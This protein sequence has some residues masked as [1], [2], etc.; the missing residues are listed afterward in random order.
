MLENDFSTFLSWSSSSKSFFDSVSRTPSP[1]DDLA[2]DSVLADFGFYTGGSKSSSPQSSIV[3]FGRF[4]EASPEVP[5]DGFGSEIR[6][7]LRDLY[8]IQDEFNGYCETVRVDS[9]SIVAQIVGKGG[10]KIKHLINKY[11]CHIQSPSPG[12]EPVFVITGGKEAV[13]KIKKELLLSAHH[14]SSI[15]RQRQ[16]RIHT[17]MSNSETTNVTIHLPAKY[18]GLVVGRFGRTV[19][20]MQKKFNVYIDTPRTRN[21]SHFV[22]YGLEHNL[23]TVLESIHQSLTWKTKMTFQLRKEKDYYIEPLH[24]ENLFDTV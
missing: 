22:I 23:K 20:E 24:S 14:F 10:V 1:D 21:S 4:S 6:D 16:E 12:E 3:N 7:D 11:S 2:I 9:S 15:S 8:N 13:L 17:I 18:V 5:V 19:R